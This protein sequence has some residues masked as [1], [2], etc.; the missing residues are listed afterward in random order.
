MRK[1]AAT[2]GFVVAVFVIVAGVYAATYNHRGI[3]DTE[4]NSLQ[5]KA[6]VLH[7]DVDLSRYGLDVRAYQSSQATL[8]AERDDRVYSVYGVGVSIVASPVYAVMLRTGMEA[9]APRV[10]AIGFSAAAAAALGLLLIKRFSLPVAVLCLVAFAFGTTT[11]PVA[12]TAF[13]QQG[14]VL[15]FLSLG[16][17]GLLSERQRPTLAG[18]GFATATLIRPTVAILLG[19]IGLLYLLRGWRRAVS[20]GAGALVPLLIL[21]VQN[22]WIWGS[23][24]EGGYGQTGVTFAEPFALRGLTVGWWRGLFIYSPVL[25]LGVVGWILSLRGKGES[26]RALSFLGISALATI[27]LYSKWADWGGGLNQFG[28]R[29]LLEIVPILIVLSAFAL[30]QL[31]KL[32][33]AGVALAIVSVVTMTWGAAPRRD[34]FDTVFF[35]SEIRQTS[36]WRAWDN[37]LENLGSSLLRLSLVAAACVVLGLVA[38]RVSPRLRDRPAEAHTG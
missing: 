30:T 7:G 11:W 20:Y 16:L 33:P 26:E 19:V 17:L 4:L 28:Y 36:L 34:G 24:L 5:T 22:R 6:L 21:V 18:L 23:W 27:L 15:F 29:L 32:M 35:A 25:M 9:E 13:F 2:V 10:T 38:R 1:R 31:K 37:A 3:T 8:V 12:S 14:S